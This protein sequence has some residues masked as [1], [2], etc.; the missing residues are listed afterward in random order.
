MKT[1]IGSLN[2]GLAWGSFFLVFFVAAVGKIGG[3]GIAARLTGLSTRESLAIG[4]AMNTK[5]LVE[6]IILNI[7]LDAKIISSQIFAIMVLFAI[8]TTL[9]TSPSIDWLLPKVDYVPS[10]TEDTKIVDAKDFRRVLEK[11]L[12]MVLAI[13]GLR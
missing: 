8:A 3:S 2:T 12:N 1:D 7:G 9:V 10:V 6:I 13:P 5:G 11:E 4:F